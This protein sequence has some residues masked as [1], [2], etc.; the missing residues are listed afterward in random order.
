MLYFLLI[1]APKTT[2]S[3]PNPT[4]SDAKHKAKAAK[5]E[6]KTLVRETND[7]KDKS[8]LASKPGRPKKK[9]L[10]QMLRKRPK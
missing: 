10:M 8:N 3:A 7:D 5:G 9:Q 2:S 4:T 1:T 6:T